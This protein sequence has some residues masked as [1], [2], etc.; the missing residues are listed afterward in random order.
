MDEVHALDAADQICPECGGKLN[1]WE[2]QFDD[3]EE[4]DVVEIQYVKRRHR[5]QKYRCTC[6]S[7]IETAL[8][9]AKLIPGGR[10]SIGFAIHVSIAKYLDHLPLER[11]V[12]RMR[13]QGL[14]VTNQTLWDQTW[15]LALR[16]EP[17]AVR[18][19]R[20]SCRC[21][22]CRA[23]DANRESD[24]LYLDNHWRGLIVF[25]TDPRRDRRGPWAWA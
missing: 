5:R 19:H 3:S 15:S 13:R 7:K 21:N 6:C 22:A 11:R 20:R 2:N 8:G 4:I 17:V 14:E 25:L 23:R 9:P 12:S 18:I 1:E 24:H 10:Y 16:L